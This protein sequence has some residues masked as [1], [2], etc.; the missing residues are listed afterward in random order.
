MICNHKE[1]FEAAFRATD[2]FKGTVVVCMG[3]FR[4]IMPVLKHANRHEVRQSC[5]ASSYL[6]YKFAVFSLSI[7]MRLELTKIKLRQRREI[8]LHSQDPT[9]A[10]EVHQLTEQL[11]NQTNYGNMILSI[12]EARGDRRDACV[13]HDCTDTGLQIYRID[14]IPHYIESSIEDALLFLYPTGFDMRRMIKCSIVAA[15]NAQVDT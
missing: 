12:G 8:I 14:S 2:G 6:W 9:L 3:D 10:E 5:I 15:T 11:N 7:N 13:M 4:Q 1:L